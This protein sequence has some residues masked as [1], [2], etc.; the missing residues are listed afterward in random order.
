MYRRVFSRPF[1]FQQ[2]Q[3]S[4]RVKD[5]E[6][7]AKPV[8]FS[9]SPLAS[10]HQQVEKLFPSEFLQ[11]EEYEQYAYGAENEYEDEAGSV[12]SSRSI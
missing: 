10:D 4:S 5:S 1:L 7:K 6:V 12:C 3:T 8:D 2:V 9:G 11:E